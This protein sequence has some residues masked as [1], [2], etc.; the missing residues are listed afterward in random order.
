[1]YTAVV[2][3]LS[4]LRNQQ[5]FDAL[6]EVINGMYV[7]VFDPYHLLLSSQNIENIRPACA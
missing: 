3:A 5:Q 6:S 2:C 7:K 1:M 4:I